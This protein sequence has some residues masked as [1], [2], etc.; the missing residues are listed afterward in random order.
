MSANQ[1]LADEAL[2][3]NDL[4][5]KASEVYG[6]SRIENPL[7]TTELVSAGDSYGVRLL[8]GG[9][10]V[11][12]MGLTEWASLSM[13]EYVVEDSV[14]VAEGL[15]QYGDNI[16]EVKEAIKQEEGFEDEDGDETQLELTRE[17]PKRT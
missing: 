10:A 4:N 9:D 1:Y 8:R 11:V 15:S 13:T 7:W 17:P 5:F 6:P 14:E 2:K 3:E 16:E 12:A